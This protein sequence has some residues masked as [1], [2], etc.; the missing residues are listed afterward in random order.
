MVAIAF[1]RLPVFYL[2]ILLLISLYSGVC[3][4]S[5]LV[6]A[7]ELSNASVLSLEKACGEHDEIRDFS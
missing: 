4:A 7:K 3:F 1:D 5:F 6:I 2:L